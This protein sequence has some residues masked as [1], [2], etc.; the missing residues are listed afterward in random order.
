MKSKKEFI[1]AVALGIVLGAALCFG[2][3]KLT[4][5]IKQDKE[6]KALGIKK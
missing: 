4:A 3:I 1:G 6:E 5:K 2:A